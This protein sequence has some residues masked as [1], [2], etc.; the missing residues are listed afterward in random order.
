[1]RNYSGNCVYHYNV[2]ILNF[3]AGSILQLIIT[4]PMIKNKLKEFLSD[5]KNFKVKTILVLN[6]KKIN[7]QKI[8]Y[9]SATLI[10]SDSCIKSMH[11]IIMTKIKIMP[12]KIALS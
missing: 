10:A 11:Q 12:V 2:K 5:F 3:F 9:L 7:Y 8:F 4:K 1:M 6:Y